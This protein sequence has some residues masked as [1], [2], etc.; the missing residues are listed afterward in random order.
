MKGLFV[1]LTTIDILFPVEQFPRE[2][3]KSRA[4]GNHM[5]LGGP[6]MN[7][8]FAFAAL[9]GEATL[10]TWIGQHAL[11]AYMHSKLAAYGIKT[12]D[13]NPRQAR[14]PIISSVIINKQNGSRT[15]VTSQ[16]EMGIEV[17]RP[18]VVIHDYEVLCVDGFFGDYLLILLEEN[19]REIPVVFDA[20]SFKSHTDRIL[21]WVHY[22]ILSGHFMHPR[23]SSP[24][25]YLERFQLEHYAIT[26]GEHP[27]K[28]FD[29]GSLGEICPQQITAIDTLA[30]GD[31]YHGAFA[32]FIVEND[33]NFPLALRQ[34]ADI[35]SLSC[36]DIGSRKWTEYL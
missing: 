6:A 14:D 36:Q 22:P 24:S 7:A 30:A 11:T 9:G 35:A 1:G 17:I 31:I 23:Y 12:I 29:R 21:P 13:L 19:N 33:R 4:K 3:E 15:I 32:K 18:S 2:N 27:I 5:D 20:G 26:N 25:D 10:I 16:V 8:A 34:A 28:Y